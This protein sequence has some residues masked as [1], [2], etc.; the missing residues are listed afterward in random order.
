[1]FKLLITIAV[2]AK[3]AFAFGGPYVFWG[4]KPLQHVH[5]GALQQFSDESLQ[6]IYSEAEAIIVFL[7]NASS[8]KVKSENYPNFVSM[9]NHHPW[10]Y[11]A[12]DILAAN[13][14]DKNSYTEVGL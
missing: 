4:I 3:G 8:P 11:L 9:L 13:P 1:M 14:A 12:K 7:R 5:V 6:Q 10:T 2:L